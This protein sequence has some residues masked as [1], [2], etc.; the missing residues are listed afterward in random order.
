MY[1]ANSIKKRDLS[2]IMLILIYRHL[3]SFSFQGPFEKM[4]LYDFFPENL[5]FIFQLSI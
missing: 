5:S 4:H 3:I 1:P 2:L